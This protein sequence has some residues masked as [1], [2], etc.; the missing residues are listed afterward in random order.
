M[1]TLTNNTTRPKHPIALSFDVEDWFTVRN[2]RDF[3][4]DSEWDKQELRVNVGMDFILNALA[5]KNIKSTFYV[6]GWLADRCPELIK[7]IADQGHEI[8]CH[9]YQHTPIDLLDPKSFEVDLKKA[10]TALEKVSGQKI[11]GFRAPSFSVMHET[12]WALPIIRDC[13]LEYDSS[14]FV[15]SHPDYG[16]RDFPT[17]VTAVHGLTEVPLKKSKFFGAEIPV[18]GGGYFRMLPYRMTKSALTQDLK[19]G[20]V[21]MYFHP[22]EFDPEQPRVAL[23]T[24]KRFRHYVGLNKNRQKFMN[25]LNDFEF[26]T[27]ENLVTQAKASNSL[28]SYTFA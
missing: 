5:E 8:G 12:S 11:K 2:M 24:L 14:I 19:N 15:T 21:V 22:W 16:V 25:L 10:L 17:S 6:L 18:C 20:P 1:S 4:S 3:V 27:V 13:G 23:P 9:S 7:K 28:S 26:T